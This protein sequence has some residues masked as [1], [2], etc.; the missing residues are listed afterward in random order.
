MTWLNL[1]ELSKLPQF[2]E[3]LTQVHHVLGVCSVLQHVSQLH[4][5]EYCMWCHNKYCASYP[6][7]MKIIV[8]PETIVYILAEVLYCR[9]DGMC[10]FVAF[11][12]V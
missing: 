12:S 2:S 10:V 1:V 7:F 8:Q 4:C 9:L 6:C 5:E 11:S 3:L